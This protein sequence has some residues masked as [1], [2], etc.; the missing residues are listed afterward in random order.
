MPE[1]ILNGID[2]ILD[3]ELGL[4]N[5]GIGK[6][7]H[8]K[9]KTS[10]QKLSESPLLTFDAT[11]LIQKIFDLIA[12]NWKDGANYRPLTE[13]WRFEPR[14][15]IDANNEDPEI[16]LERAIVRAYTQSHAT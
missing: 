7:P 16:K 14:T 11:A 1:S 13:N 12:F 10:F 15:N 5:C 3:E 4:K 6:A 8:Y 9:H 2:S